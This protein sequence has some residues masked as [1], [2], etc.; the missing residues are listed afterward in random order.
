[1]SSRRFTLKLAAGA[2]ATATALTSLALFA[3]CGGGDDNNGN[4]APTKHDSGTDS[5]MNHPD[6]STNHE[7]GGGNE[8]GAPETGLPDTGSCVSDSSACNSCYTDAQAA[9]DPLNSCSSFTKN[10]VPFTTTVPTH[11][12]L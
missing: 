4:P 12:T 5:S 3:G 7:G 1:M 11:P 6:T 9:T 2:L 10:C 8:T